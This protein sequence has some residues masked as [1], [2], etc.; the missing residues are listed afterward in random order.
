MFLTHHGE[1]AGGDWLRTFRGGE[2]EEHHR[3]DAGD[4]VDAA[5][6]LEAPGAWGQPG[7][8]GGEEGK[9][10]MQKSAIVLLL[11]CVGLWTVGETEWVHGGGAG[12]P[13]LMAV[14]A[15]SAKQSSVFVPTFEATRSVT[16]RIEE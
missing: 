16:Q 7:P 8:R 13:D 4:R 6:A 9:D 12:G 14:V 1:V 11:I 3:P 5:P 15:G 2:D 10:D